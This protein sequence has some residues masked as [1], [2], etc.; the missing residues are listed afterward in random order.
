MLRAEP[1]TVSENSEWWVAPGSFGPGWGGMGL[2][3]HCEVGG[4][5]GREMSQGSGLGGGGARPLPLEGPDRVACERL[6]SCR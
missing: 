6:R 2:E 3:Q 1:S 4:G 5:Q